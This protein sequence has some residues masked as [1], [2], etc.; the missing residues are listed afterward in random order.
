MAKFDIEN[1]ADSIRPEGREEANY[2]P[3]RPLTGLSTDSI[4]MRACNVAVRP[5]LRGAAPQLGTL[6]IS[7]VFLVAAAASADPVAITPDVPP[8]TQPPPR[9]QQPLP[10]SWDLDGLY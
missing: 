6:V 10:P 4:R 5:L 9:F 7:A 1:A 2:E 8:R 3:S